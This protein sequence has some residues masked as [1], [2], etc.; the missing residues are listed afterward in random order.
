MQE[1]PSLRKSTREQNRNLHQRLRDN[2][3]C[4]RNQPLYELLLYKCGI[5]SHSYFLYRSQADDHRGQAPKNSLKTTTVT[6][7]SLFQLK[8]YGNSTS[9]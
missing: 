7:T 6:F 1:L 4:N 3:H 2:L 5:F 9:T 8:I